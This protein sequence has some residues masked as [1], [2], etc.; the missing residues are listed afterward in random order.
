MKYDVIIIGSGPAGLS[1]G[2]YAARAKM[3]TLII[4][5]ER[6]GGQIVT[7][8]DVANY[9]GA[10]V[11]TTG[12]SLTER[13]VEQ[14]EQFGAQMITAEVIRVD[15]DSQVKSV[16]TSAGVFEAPSIIV[17]TGAHP[18]KMGLEAE[19]KFVGR[20][21]SYCA[22]CDADFFSDLP[23]LVI[24][25]GDTAIE[26]A[27]FLTK[28][29]SEVTIVHRRDEFRAAK[30]YIEKALNHPKIKTIMNTKVKDI[31]GDKRLE[32][33]VLENTVTGEVFDYM[34]EGGF[35]GIFV[36]VGYIPNT[37]IFENALNLDQS[38]Y[39]LTDEGMKTNIKGV[40][41]AGDVRSKTLRQ[42][43]TATADGAI[44]AVEAEKYNDHN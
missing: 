39:I 24:G 27:L 32:K 4:E 10:P 23:V 19:D 25:G 28:F 38:G 26:E 2:L 6:A 33:V 7:T 15:F 35:F 9:P 37:K 34:P 12:P 18:R 5:K 40:F 36:F 16:E 43:V 44:A 3:K 13:M 21:I 1:A 17:A 30:M 14:V 8:H 11:G 42:V 29:A 20:G 41:A 31:V 22:T